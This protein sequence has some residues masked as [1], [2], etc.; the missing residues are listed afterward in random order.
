ML[1]VPD[2]AAL[3]RGVVDVRSVEDE[4][5]SAE[6]DDTGASR[7]MLT[8]KVKFCTRKVISMLHY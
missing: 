8:G 3:C 6:Q 1:D 7:R 4:I 2:F 5:K